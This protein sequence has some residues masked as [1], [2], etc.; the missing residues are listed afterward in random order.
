MAKGF[1]LIEVLLSVAIIGL[2]TGVSLPIYA[3]FANRNDLEVTTE[4]IVRS[5]RRA[6]SYSRGV[7][8][9]SQWG[10]AIQ[11]GTIVVFKGATYATRDTAF[12]EATIIPNNVSTSGFSEVAFSKL[13]G[14]PSATA[15]INLSTINNDTRTVTLN[16]EG[17]VNY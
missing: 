12:D 1:T 3:S 7:N 8:Y 10:V 15:N 9:D 11:S 6:Q 13:Y 17:M 2:L 4:N 14:A 16:A 5:L